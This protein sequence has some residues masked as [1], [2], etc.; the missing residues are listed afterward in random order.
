MTVSNAAMLGCSAMP[1]SIGHGMAVQVTSGSLLSGLA[2][3][4]NAVVE[5]SVSERPVT[6]WPGMAVVVDQGSSGRVLKRRGGVGRGSAVRA[7]L[8]S[9]RMGWASH[10]RIGRSCYVSAGYG[11]AWP[12][13]VGQV[14]AVMVRRVSSYRAGARSGRRGLNDHPCP[15]CPARIAELVPEMGE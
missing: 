13:S 14:L 9:G 10:V 7:P 2:C 6:A 15:D 12:R 4:S 3:L 1:P 5:R 8:V 11:M